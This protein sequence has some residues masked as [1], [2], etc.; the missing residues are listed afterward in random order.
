MDLQWS[1]LGE[2]LGRIL[3]F[4]KTMKLPATTNEFKHFLNESL[5]IESGNSICIL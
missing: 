1:Q 2:N 5:L 4:D 3:D